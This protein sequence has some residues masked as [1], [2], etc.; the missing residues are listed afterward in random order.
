MKRKLA[1]VP[2]LAAAT[3]AC[4]FAPNYHKPDMPVPP[5]Y[6]ESVDWKTAQ[7]ADEA[8]RGAWWSVFQDPALDALEAKVTNANQDLKAAFARLEQARAET[9]I[10]RADYF[11]TVTASAGDTRARTSQHAPLYTPGAPPVGSDFVLGADLTYEA[12]VWGRVRNEVAAAKASEQASAAD[13]A[14]LDLSTHA[15]MA[16]DWFMLRGDDSQQAL[17]DRT[18]VDYAK[19]LDLT[20]NLYQG[21]AA[22]AT[23]VAQAQ[24]Q[25][26]TARTQAEDIRLQRAQLEHAIAVLAGE[27][28]E[29]FHLDPMP[30]DG[31]PPA[32]DT[33]LPSALLERRPDIA[34]AE[35]RVASANAGIGEARAAYFPVFSLSAEAGFESTHSFNWIEAPSRF[36]SLGPTGVLTVFDAGRHSA[37]SAQAHGVYDETVADYRGSVLNA[38]R[39]VEDNLAALR[40]LEKES[41]S[42]AAA[43]GA[44]GEE[45]RQANLRYKGGIATY[46]EVVTAE[47][48]SL[49]A[50]ITAATILQ[51]RMSAAVLLIKALG[52]DWRGPQ[53]AGSEAPAPAAAVV[54]AAA[55]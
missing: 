42:E 9:R 14:T 19:A 55:G 45:L 25:L 51:R 26:D 5:A 6:V 43:V 17:L 28:T 27:P 12:D 49:S 8:Q 1:A 21:G 7:P 38:Y 16:G 30:L 35:R 54:P 48:A 24:A 36:W 50:R 15:E 40:Q 13:L 23:D 33:G 34:A 31:L 4:N 29:G 11:P 10:A 41:T 52:G 18:V 2:V 22:S 3:A 39:E 37:Q 53:P 20:Q 32:I 46:L 47:N 44:T